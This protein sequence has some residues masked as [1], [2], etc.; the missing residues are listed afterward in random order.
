MIRSIVASLPNLSRVCLSLVCAY[1]DF[2]STGWA[3]AS[4]MSSLSDIS[5][6]DFPPLPC[7]IIP[8]LCPN[9][10]IRVLR[11]NDSSASTFS[12]TLGALASGPI[13]AS[14]T[15]S[16][17]VSVSS[18][19]SVASSDFSGIESAASL[20]VSRVGVTRLLIS[21]SISLISSLASSAVDSSSLVVAA[22]RVACA[23]ESLR[24]SSS[25]DSSS[26]TSSSTTSS[27][28]TSGSSIT[29]VV[30]PSAT[31][32][33]SSKSSE[34]SMSPSISSS[35]TPFSAS[36]SSSF[37]ASFSAFLF[38]LPNSASIFASRSLSS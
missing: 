2:L 31:S 13:T 12:S 1:C 34:G 17:G 29:S 10:F 11:P 25:L 5:D 36:S 23:S 22:S 24:A 16:S 21:P 19:P 7:A 20:A 33:P 6:K 27:S 28:T 8:S 9:L 3:E 15:V 14:S 18:G 32:V 37:L 26:T 30:G 4:A 38:R 35:S